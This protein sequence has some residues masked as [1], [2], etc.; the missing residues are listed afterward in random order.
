MEDVARAAGVSMVTVSRALN[1]PDKVASAT[2]ADVRS[3]IER[4]RYVHNLTAGS[5]A[6]RRSRIVAAIVPTIAS[7]IFSDTVD[8]LAQALSPHR[9][10]LLLGQSD[11][12]EDEEAA[13]IA[14][15]LGRGVDGLLLIGVKH[16]RGVRATLQRAGIPVVETWD[17]TGRPI[18]MLVGFSNEEA[19]RAAARHLIGKGYGSLGFIGGADDRSASR[20]QGFRAEARAQGLD[21]IA[22]A[23]VPAPSSVPDGAAAMGELLQGASPPRAVFCTNDML[24]AGARFHCQRRGIDIPGGIA[25]MGF[26]D[27]PIAACMEPALTSVQVRAHAMGQRAGELMI[28]RL[29]GAPRPERIIDL[30]FAVIERKSA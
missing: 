24:A 19:G 16:A 3:A 28:G 14:A 1:T 26:A 23:Q 4:L 11:Y 20:L 12:R 25:L 15:F 30:G 5:L 18:D 8:G 10:Q 27:L 13:L 29:T 7:S 21:D 9:Y 22:V 17:L 6:S 2:L